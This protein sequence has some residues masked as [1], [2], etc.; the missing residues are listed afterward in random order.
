MEHSKYY[1]DYKRNMNE[2]KE[3]FNELK[4]NPIPN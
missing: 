3:I 2:H 4:S 1:Y